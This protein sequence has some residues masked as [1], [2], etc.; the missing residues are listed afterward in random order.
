MSNTAPHVGTLKHD[1]DSDAIMVWD[2]LSWQEAK[3]ALKALPD[4]MALLELPVGLLTSKDW[5][6]WREVIVPLY[7]DALH[8]TLFDRDN[9]ATASAFNAAVEQWRTMLV[10]SGAG[11]LDDDDII[12]YA[13]N[14]TTPMPVAADILAGTSLQVSTGYAMP[15]KHSYSSSTLLQKDK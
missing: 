13:V 7:L 2:G 12:R 15:V 1:A 4:R 5:P 10:L 8:D 11:D 3:P 9:T 6:A 14:R